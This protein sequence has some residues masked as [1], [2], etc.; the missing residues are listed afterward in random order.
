[1]ECYAKWTEKCHSTFSRTMADIFKEWTNQFVKVFVDDVNVHS[2]TWDEHLGHIKLVLQKLKRVNLKLNPSKC[3]FDSKSITFLGH[4][5]DNAG[6]QPDP[7]KIAI[8]QHFPTPKIAT[9]VKAFLGLTRY[10][11]KFIARYTKIVE[12]LFALTKKD[13]K[14]LWMPIC[15]LTFIALKRRIVEALVLVKPDFNKPFIL[16][17]DWSIRGVEAILSQKAGGQK[18]VIAYASKGLYIVQH[19]FSSHG[20]RVLCSHLGHHV[21]QAISLLNPIFVAHKS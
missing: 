2:G 5:V 9:N 7:R 17:F 3:C 11:R 8:V 13:C 19:C 6:S 1:M 12:P 14:F 21:L 16:D 18:E 4:V 20:G 15:H 10:Y